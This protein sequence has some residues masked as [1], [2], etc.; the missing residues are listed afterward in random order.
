MECAWTEASLLAPPFF[1]LGMAFRK[2]D[3]MSYLHP[4]SA[5]VCGLLFFGDT[6]AVGEGRS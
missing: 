6:A 1:L 3:G 4:V 5:L 2:S